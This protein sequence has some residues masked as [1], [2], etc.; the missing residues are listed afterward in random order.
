VKEI[1]RNAEEIFEMNLKLYEELL[2][3]EAGTQGIGLS[4]MK[5]ISLF[6]QYNTYCT[7][8]SDAMAAIEKL[9]QTNQPFSQFCQLVKAYS[10]SQKQDLSSVTIKPFQRV[11]RYPLL[12]GELAKQTPKNSKDLNLLQTAIQR[13]DAVVQEA[14]EAKRM[15]DSV[16][17]MIEIQNS[18]AWQGEVNFTIILFP[19]I[20][21]LVLILI[22]FIWFL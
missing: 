1:F 5:V 16:V 20:Y 7:S 18:F 2:R 15:L 17:K 21:F 4:F 11:T 19:F 9:L 6:P 22:L 3:A 13:I 14:N 8:Q 12:L 10:Q